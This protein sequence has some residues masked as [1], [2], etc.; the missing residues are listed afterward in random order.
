VISRR[1]CVHR[2]AAQHPAR[3]SGRTTG[4]GRVSSEAGTLQTDGFWG[5]ESRGATLPVSGEGVETEVML[6]DT[7]KFLTELA[8]M[9][10]RNQTSGT[11][12]LTM[13]R[14][15]R[16]YTLALG[17]CLW[18]GSHHVRTLDGSRPHN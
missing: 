18:W 7:D 15:A 3:L 8:K 13:K 4:T 2:A 9:Y 11:V 1:A 16:P 14:S 10:E 5:G 6:Y 17:F 12:W